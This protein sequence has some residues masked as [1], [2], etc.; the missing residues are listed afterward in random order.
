MKQK[1]NAI[2]QYK[3][4]VAL[5]DIMVEE[6]TYQLKFLICNGEKH[7]ILIVWGIYPPEVDRQQRLRKEKLSLKKN[8]VYRTS[9]KTTGRFKM[10][11]P[12]NSLHCSLGN[13]LVWA[14]RL[15]DWGGGT[16]HG[17]I[18]FPACG[19]H[20]KSQ[21]FINHKGYERFSFL[22][23]GYLD[24][25]DLTDALGS[26]KGNHS[27]LGFFP[28]TCKVKYFATSKQHCRGQGIEVKVWN[29]WIC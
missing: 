15:R 7:K 29:I 4:T 11:S 12:K 20:F 13:Y 9:A 5:E 8:F 3:F 23:D 19:T 22:R 28:R 10:A 14:R 26:K 25:L 1:K 21:S 18:C 16:L 24:T 2:P 27:V 17:S 6:F